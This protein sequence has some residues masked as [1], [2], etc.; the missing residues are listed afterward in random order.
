MSGL[1]RVRVAPS[2]SRRLALSLLFALALHGCERTSE[3]APPQATSK[4]SRSRQ[5]ASA[6]AFDLVPAPGGAVLAW[7]LAGGRL[8]WMR[9]DA[10]T[11]P[12]GEGGALA[13]VDEGAVVSEVALAAIGADV[14]LAWS[15]ASAG[16]ATLR[17]AW[18]ASDGAARL[19]ELGASSPPDGASRGALAL[20]G[21]ERGALL[22]ARGGE[23][24][25]SDARERSCSAFQFFEIAP[26]A[27]KPTGLSLTVPNPCAAHSAQLVSARRGA[28]GVASPF[29][30]AICAG[31]EGASALTVFSI[32]PSPAYAAAEEALAGCVPLGAGRFGGEATFVGVCSGQRRSVSVPAEGGAL[33]AR[34]LDERGLVCNAGGA[35]LRF[36]NGW[37]RPSEPLGSLEL[38]LNDDLAPAGA[39]AVWTGAGLLVAQASDGRLS[40]RRYACRHTQLRELDAPPDAGG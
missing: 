32:Q 24:P 6:T 16:Q 4:A 2:V 12:V 37:L 30:Y 18:L 17:A 36:G 31:P 22:L 1:V 20:V 34:S 15:E 7:A 3:V 40:L 38:L 5:L 23:A 11:H 27:A 10:E 33:V 14:A 19:F 8:Q 29:E 39:R 35:R 9:F 26:D 28:A 21:R 13:R 25:C